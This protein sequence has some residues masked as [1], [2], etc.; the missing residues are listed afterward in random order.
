MTCIY[1]SWCNYKVSSYISSITELGG[2]AQL[3]LY[4]YLSGEDIICDN[5]LK[6]GEE[7][8]YPDCTPVVEDILILPVD[9]VK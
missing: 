6:E 9:S 5:R 1:K 7:Q 8:V 2:V 3:H 4:L